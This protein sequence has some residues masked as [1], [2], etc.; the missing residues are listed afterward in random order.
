MRK[1]ER[2]LKR[3]IR[4]EIIK[5][6]NKTRCLTSG[7]QFHTKINP[8]SVSIEVDMP[9]DLNMSEDE[10]EVLE[11]LLHNAIELVLR[12]YFEKPDTFENSLGDYEREY[13]YTT[14]SVFL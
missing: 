7:A 2:L 14:S 13:S 10:S 11:T 6:Q 8:S 5:E 9:F 12:P 1:D 4:Q 3:L